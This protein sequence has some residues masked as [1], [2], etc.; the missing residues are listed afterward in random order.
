MRKNATI[1]PVD[2]SV[3]YLKAHFT[4]NAHTG[5][6]REQGTGSRIGSPNSQDGGTRIPHNGKDMSGARVAWI[7][8]TGKNIPVGFA[9]TLRERTPGHYGNRMNN[10]QPVDIV[11]NPNIFE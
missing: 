3:A 10:L 8:A 4:Y 11:A 2:F 5:E 6:I 7:L 1:T 9:I